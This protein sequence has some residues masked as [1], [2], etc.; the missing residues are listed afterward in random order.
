[1]NIKEEITEGM[2]IQIGSRDVKVV[3]NISSIKSSPVPVKEMRKT[4]D[5]KVD[6]NAFKSPLIELNDEN[7]KSIPSSSSSKRPTSSDNEIHSSKRFKCPLND[8]SSN[9][10][11]TNEKQ[12]EIPSSVL[13]HLKEYQKEGVEFMF[14]S[15]MGKSTCGFYGCIL[16]DEMGLGKTL[17]TLALM[18]TLRKLNVAKRVL[19]VSP[20]SLVANWNREIEKWLKDQRIFTFVA[21]GKKTI[22]EFANSI[23]IPIML[24]SYEMLLRQKEDIKKITFD[25]M[26]LDE[27]HRMKNDDS[28]TYKAIEEFKCLRRV[29]LTGTPFQN[30]IREFFS[31]VNL[32]NPGIFGRYEDFRLH[33]EIPILRSQN[34]NATEEEIEISREKTLE[35]Q[36]KSSSFMIRR[37]QSEIEHELPMKQELIVLVR[38]SQLQQNLITRLLE[39]Y[40]SNQSIVDFTPLEIITIMK[41]ICN[42][43]YLMSNQNE[44]ENRL[45]TELFSEFF[46]RQTF[47][48]P[49]AKSG[50]LK[51]VSS[52]LDDINEKQEKVVIVSYSTKTLDMLE[53]TLVKKNLKFTRLDG[54]T[55]TQE[56][57]KIV[58]DFNNPNSETFC[59]LLSAKSGGVGLNLV[60]ASRL[61]LFDCDWN[62]ANDA[63]ACARIFRQGQTQNVFIYRFITCGTIE[64]KILQRQ[65]SKNTLGEAIFDTTTISNN[66]GNMFNESETRELFN[67]E[68]HNFLDC[69]THELIGCKCDGFGEVPESNFDNEEDFES[70][71]KTETVNIHE[72]MKYEH[73]KKPFDETFLCEIGLGNIEDEIV[74]L[75]RR[76]VGEFESLNLEHK[77]NCVDMNE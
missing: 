11:T 25:L 69:N 35:I 73:Y 36:E 70:S 60:G 71:T 23:H 33:Y 27:G 5:F 2:N 12:F 13:R 18:L 21:D 44:K 28:K 58:N 7:E 74:F 20:S 45:I 4:T 19:I 64:E 42:H 9:K 43:P 22:K 14:D 26:I 51:V 63:Q 76:T 34:V 29:L 66:L 54:S 24:V 39:F 1:M 59:F 65:I 77:T 61:I 10:S 53:F 32:V 48:F 62:P 17:Q 47:N 38:P 37:T 52:L 75:F 49:I 15:V 16:A 67:I 57:S 8:E 30:D 46:Q 6:K 41:K 55:K 56:R 40:N 31:I 68:S 72:L 3:D 50:K